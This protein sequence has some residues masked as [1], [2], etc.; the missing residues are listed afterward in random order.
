M[1]AKHSRPDGE[2]CKDAGL[3]LVL[4]ALVC[5]QFWELP[6]LVLAATGVLLLAM[7]WPR[8]FYPFAVIWFALSEVLGAV[9]S[10]LIL[11]SLFF[12]LVLPI[13]LIRR[14]LGKD[15]MGLRR[16]K[17]G[18]ESV[19]RNREHKFVASDLDHPY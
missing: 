19:F 1:F 6:Q 8:G 16:W 17:K 2:K 11:S 14:V 13:G 5:Y 18:E 3:A 4:I 9:T 15:S 7:I 10:R 12:L